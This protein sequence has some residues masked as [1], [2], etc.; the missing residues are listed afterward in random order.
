MGIVKAIVALALVCGATLAGAADEVDTLPA[1]EAATR[2]L[3]SVDGGAYG[4]SWDQASAS[5]QKALTREA[6]EKALVGARTPLGRAGA[7]KVRS[8]TVAR[9]LPNAPP[10]EYVV[11]QYETQFELRPAVEAVTPMREPD[12]RW[13]VSGYFIR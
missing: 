12:G 13:R 6:W 8:V 2:W 4:A 3:E 5:F 11:I 10:G 1:Q 9:N 7:R